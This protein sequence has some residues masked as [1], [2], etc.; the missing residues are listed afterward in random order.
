M[1]LGR[2]WSQADTPWGAWVAQLVERLALGF[3]S[4]HDLTVCE[5]K[6]RVKLCADSGKPVWDSLS[7]S[8]CPRSKQ[9]NKL[10]KI[11]NKI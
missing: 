1:E 10:K 11:K 4:R 2:S 9:I 7:A 5:F 6:P 3:G 8:P